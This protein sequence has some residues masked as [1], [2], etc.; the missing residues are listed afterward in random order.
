MV[1]LQCY[2]SLNHEPTTGFNFTIISDH[3]SAVLIGGIDG[4]CESG[5]GGGR[6]KVRSDTCLHTVYGIRCRYHHIE[7]IV[8]PDPAYSLTRCHV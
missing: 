2:D 5:G 4:Q 8:T 1:R 3:L 6:K 7:V